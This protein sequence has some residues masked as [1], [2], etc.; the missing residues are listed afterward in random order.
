MP[1]SRN[2]FSRVV[3]IACIVAVLLLIV[4]TVVILSPG[5]T[6]A[7]SNELSWVE[8]DLSAATFPSP[9]PP[10]NPLARDPTLNRRPGQRVDSLQLHSSINAI[11]FDPP[12]RMHLGDFP[13]VPSDTKL[14]GKGKTGAQ[15]EGMTRELVGPQQVYPSPDPQSVLEAQGWTLQV[16]EDFEGPF[17]DGVGCWTTQDYGPDGFDRTWGDDDSRAWFGSWAAW[18]AS[19]GIDGLDPAIT[20]SYSDNLDS[21]MIC[22]PFDFSNAADAFVDFGMWLDTELY[23]DWLF[24][25]ASVDNYLF[26]GYRWSGYSGG[27]WVEE[28]FWLSPY[29]GYSQ[30]WLAWVFTSDASIS[31]YEGAWVD[32]ISVWT[33]ELP[34]LDDAGNL[35]QD[36][37]FEE[38]GWAWIPI[39]ISVQSSVNASDISLSDL[40]TIATDVDPDPTQVLAPA[41]SYL[42]NLTAVHGEWSAYMF[43]NGELDD[44]LVQP[45]T[46]PVGT[47]DIQFG[48]WFGVTTDETTPGTDWFCASLADAALETLI[49]DLGCLDA[50]YATGYVHLY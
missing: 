22:G 24:F 16:Y 38:G 12:V 1:T 49:V 31:D 35:V 5:R 30:V 26:E 2:L 48:F 42:T 46:V 13:Q 6:L 33:Y 41:D 18:P 32:E 40:T 36:G 7:Q 10:L 27:E 4:V 17:G 23:Y 45:I 37:S 25:G 47:T 43:A 50:A 20:G 8:S 39:T 44:Y 11:E 19:G 9:P 29:A 28:P 14:A 15:R 3:V 34:P 21:W